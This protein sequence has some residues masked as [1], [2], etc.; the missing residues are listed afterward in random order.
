MSILRLS[1]QFAVE[2]ARVVYTTSEFCFY[3]P[4]AFLSFV[5]ITPTKH[6]SLISTVYL[7]FHFLE[8]K[9]FEEW[10]DF[11]AKTD[12][13][14]QFKSLSQLYLTLTVLPLPTS[15]ESFRFKT[16]TVDLKRQEI[17][18]D[19]EALRMLKLATLIVEIQSVRPRDSNAHV[20]RH[21]KEMRDFVEG[22]NL[23]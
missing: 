22:R 14:R 12:S 8:P 21:M 1:R 2:A 13:L 4:K 23:G 6:L 11:L 10:D 17:P 16:A 7:T 5:A 9:E 15:G 3:K 18:W 20:S 19:F